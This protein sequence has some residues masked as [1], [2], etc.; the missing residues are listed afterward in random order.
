[1]SDDFE[2]PYKHHSRTVGYA[3]EDNKWIQRAKE[4]AQSTS[5]DKFV[6]TGAV[7]VKDGKE[8]GFGANGSETHIKHGCRRIV[9]NSKTGEDYH[10]CEGCQPHNHAEF[11][12]IQSAKQK[13]SSLIHCDLYLWG[14]Y[15]ICK[16]CWQLIEK[17]KITRVFLIENANYL[18]N[19]KN[20]NNILRK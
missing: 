17:N 10:L 2:Y 7:I 16:D 18:F 9:M 13:L 4:V 6:P 12:A 8:L 3:R 1:M 11:R 20:P 15:G 19:K 14:H 5:L